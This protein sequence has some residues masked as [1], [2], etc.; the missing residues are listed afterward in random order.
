MRHTSETVVV[1]NIFD[2]VRVFLNCLGDREA[3][4]RFLACVPAN[5]LEKADAVRVCEEFNGLEPGSLQHFG[6]DSSDIFHPFLDLYLA[7]LLGVLQSDPETGIAYQRFRR[8]HDALT[9]SATDLP[10]SPI[11][12]LHPAL[13]T[14][15]RGQRARAHSCSTSMQ[16]WEITCPG[17]RTFPRSCKSRK[18]S[19]KSIT[20]S[21]LT[22][23]DQVLK[24]MQAILTSAKIPFAGRD[25]SQ[26]GLE[27]A[28]QHGRR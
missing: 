20:I 2:E 16:L 7:G 11:F 13:D 19:K 12:L 10:G 21:S 4:L 26:Q 27:E 23:R 18:H 14:V 5:I 22:W 28:M 17:S 6:E 24:R 1:S 9:G 8:P 3:R 25:G 15:I